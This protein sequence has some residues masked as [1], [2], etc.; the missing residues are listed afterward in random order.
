MTKKNSPVTHPLTAAAEKAQL[1][2]LG[3]QF[4]PHLAPPY[5]YLAVLAVLEARRARAIAVDVVPERGWNMIAWKA[6]S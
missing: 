3:D 4:F 2:D 5:R 6:G 1:N